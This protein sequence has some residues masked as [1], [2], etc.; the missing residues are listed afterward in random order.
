MRLNHATSTHEEGLLLRV[1]APALH[2]GALTL[3]HTLP[4]G[5]MC[6]CGPIACERKESG[7]GTQVLVNLTKKVKAGAELGQAQIKLELEF[8]SFEIDSLNHI[9]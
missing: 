4:G 8:T 2:P 5:D 3:V 1:V 7:S 9:G 6:G